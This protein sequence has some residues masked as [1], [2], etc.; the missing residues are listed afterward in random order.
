[1]T[2]ATLVHQ[3]PKPA[4]DEGGTSGGPDFNLGRQFG[5]RATWRTTSP[6]APYLTLEVQAYVNGHFYTVDG[7]KLEAVEWGETYGDDGVVALPP[8]RDASSTCVRFY[9]EAEVE[10]VGHDNADDASNA[11]VTPPYI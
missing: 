3:D 4:V 7:R 11:T 8:G 10:V 9:A 2:E 5:R 1:M 6:T